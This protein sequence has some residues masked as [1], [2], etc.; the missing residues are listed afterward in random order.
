MNGFSI[1][2]KFISTNENVSNLLGKGRQMP[3]HYGSTELHFQTISSPLGTQLPH[4]AGAAY[5]F[6]R[7]GKGRVVCLYQS[8]F[9]IGEQCYYLFN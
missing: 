2:F 4:A 8:C 5:A 9:S 1:L 7:E 3:V 6:K